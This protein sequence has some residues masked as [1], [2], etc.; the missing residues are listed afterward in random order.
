MRE[1]ESLGAQ[2]GRAGW[3]MESGGVLRRLA[4]A[5]LLSAA[6]PWLALAALLLW[7]WHRADLFH[8]VPTYGDVL[9]G[10][11][12]VT[13]MAEALRLGADPGL[14]P[15]AFHPSGWQVITYAWG[16][17]N[18]LLLLPLYWLG[19]AAFS[20]NASTMIGFVIAFAGM[21]LLARR[22]L[23]RLAATTV[24]L[25]FTAWG[26]R[27]YTTTG[28][29]NIGL[30]SA[31]LPWLIWAL[32]Q[33]RQSTHRPL[34]WYAVAG[35]IWAAAANSS[36]YYIWIAG[37]AY[38]GWLIGWLLL[39][40]RNW[41]ATVARS[42]LAPLMAALFSLPMVYL[43]WRATASTGAP[44]FSVYDVNLLGAKSECSA[45]PL[46]GASRAG[47]AWTEHLSGGRL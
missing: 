18:F 8:T 4:N 20:Y 26:L 9:E 10:T 47:P 13:W 32:E 6:L 29:L 25:M 35:I 31:L 28:Q 12:A 3:R 17:T 24:A 46:A 15:L 43:F 30:G 21:Y 40:R 23:P 19:G 42:L 1:E 37:A 2:G 11:W 34:V 36:L 41:P 14:Y 16:P 44:F 5:S 22:F 45:P 33:A 38:A 27:W 7:G 39:N